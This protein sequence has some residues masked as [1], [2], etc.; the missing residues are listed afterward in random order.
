LIA[1]AIRAVSYEWAKRGPATLLTPI[2]IQRAGVQNTS[3]LLEGLIEGSLQIDAADAP[4]V[5]QAAARGDAVALDLICW[6]GHELGELANCVIRQ[7]N[8]EDLEF[9]VVQVGSLYDGSP[10]LTEAL[11][12]TVLTLAPRARFMRLKVPPVVGAVLLGMEQAGLTP[13]VELRQHLAESMDRFRQTP[14]AAS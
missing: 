10:L 2:L 8:F 7:L 11:R 14:M 5:F 4:L 3:D 9:D 6:A 12:E 13:G 1:G